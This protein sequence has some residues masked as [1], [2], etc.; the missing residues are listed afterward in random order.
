MFG[1]FWGPVCSNLWDLQDANVVCRQ[2]GH[3]G[4]LAAPV[5]HGSF[6]GEIIRNEIICLG[7]MECSGN[8]SSILH[9][10]HDEW[11]FSSE[12]SEASFGIGQS[13]AICTPKGLSSYY[14]KKH[15]YANFRI[16]T[17]PS[18]MVSCW[19][20]IIIQRLKLLSCLSVNV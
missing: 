20:G 13:M 1:G 14:V 4:A 6:D 8:E 3:D 7:F 11:K 12:D 19:K 18:N 16:F 5:Y 17:S 2:L 15:N 10:A 9:C